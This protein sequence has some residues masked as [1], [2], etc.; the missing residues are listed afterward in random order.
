MDL[1]GTETSNWSNPELAHVDP[2]DHFDGAVEPEVFDTSTIDPSH[3]IHLIRQ[4][5]PNGTQLDSVRSEFLPVGLKSKTAASLHTGKNG[6]IQEPLQNLEGAPIP[7]NGTIYAG[8]VLEKLSSKQGKDTDASSPDPALES[9]STAFL[10]GDLKSEEGS[11][12]VSLIQENGNYIQENGN[13]IEE[14]GYHFEDNRELSRK[15]SR[16]GGNH[17]EQN[18]DTSDYLPNGISRSSEKPSGT[19][20]GS[21]RPGKAEGNVEERIGGT[22]DVGCAGREL[23]SDAH[24][25]TIGGD[26]DVR[27]E[28]GCVLW[29]LA[30]TESHAE[31]LVEHHIL[32]VLL[33]FLS[34]PHSDRMREICLGVF[35]NLACHPGPVKAMVA[36][37]GL[38]ETIVRQLFVDNIPSLT[39]T[40]RLLSA[41]LHS[42]VTVAWVES[43]KPDN[44]LERIMW[45]AVNTLDSQLLE[46]CTELIL[47]MVDSRRDAAFVLLP[48]L[49]RLGLP[50]LLTDLS[51]CELTSIHEGTS[52]RGDVVLDIVLQIAEAVSIQDE[53]APQL[54]ASDDLFALSCQV[55]CLSAK[56]EIGPSGITATVLIANLLTEESGLIQR[57]LNDALFLGRLL[58]LVPC[59]GEDPGARNALWSILGRICRCLVSTTLENPSQGTEKMLAVLADG[60]SL[61]LDDLDVHQEDDVEEDE[62]QALAGHDA[63]ASTSRGLQAKLATVDN[64][65]RIMDKWYAARGGS[66]VL[67]V[68]LC[69]SVR[70]ARSLLKKYVSTNGVPSGS[71]GRDSSGAV[72]N[73]DA[74]SSVMASSAKS[75]VLADFKTSQSP[76]N[77]TL[78]EK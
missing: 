43:I 73:G 23:E 54:A 56:D 42:E 66:S 16:G 59:A 63:A 30:A 31:F 22:A 32:D 51:D 10:T 74:N 1:P 18:G 26:D 78:L 35:G 12:A 34:V 46:K 69:R 64:L 71:T 47:A 44:V 20:P 5:L 55:I 28:A 40:C 15:R 48:S 36:T 60:C 21:V 68:P 49:L 62:D 29:D 39:E 8:Q 33:A 58:A 13:H 38:V 50:G 53:C 75:D 19:S 9:A 72:Q 27:E 11:P 41:G 17:L 77:D 2:S 7:K 61:L 4:L 70:N 65:K 67:E 45:M 6:I 57:V 24:Q 3:I 52:T 76:K 25:R 37:Y 14:N